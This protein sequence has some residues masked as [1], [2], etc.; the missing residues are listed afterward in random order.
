MRPLGRVLNA[1]PLD[2]EDRQFVDS[3]AG[4]MSTRIET[5]IAQRLSR[6]FRPFIG[7]ILEVAKGLRPN[8][9]CNAVK[10]QRGGGE[11]CSDRLRRGCE[12]MMYR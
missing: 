12:Q 8:L 9:H 7:S 5:G 11:S 2:L 4:E 6:A 1:L 3:L 10:R